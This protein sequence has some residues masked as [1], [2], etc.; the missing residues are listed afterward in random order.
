[1]LKLEANMKDPNL[2]LTV[3][4]DGDIQT[5]AIE[6]AELLRHIYQGISETSPSAAE[7]YKMLIT[8]FVTNPNSPTWRGEEDAEV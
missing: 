8:H 5:L 6:T 1:M 7:T 3:E 4:M 2:A